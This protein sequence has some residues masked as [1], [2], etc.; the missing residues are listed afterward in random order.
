[1][2]IYLQQAEV[3]GEQQRLVLSGTGGIRK[4]QLAIAYAKRHHDIYESVFCL[5]AASEATLKRSLRSMAESIF[6]IQD[7]TVLG[8]EQIFIHL[9][10][11]LSD[12]S[13]TRWLLIFDNYEEPDSYKL[14]K[15]YP[16]GSHGSITVTTRLPDQVKGRQV[17]VGPKWMWDY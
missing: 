8:D 15:Y 16:Y 9:N 11:W 7:H 17:L 10:R 2:F 13:N 4:T 5:N 1:L 12:T 6:D 3:L 14:Q